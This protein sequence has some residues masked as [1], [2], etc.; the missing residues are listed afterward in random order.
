MLS[1][2]D[3][4]V[5]LG[6]SG[7]FGA[8][9]AALLDGTSVPTLFIASRTKAIRV[10]DLSYD[11]VTWDLSAMEDFHPSVVI[12]CAFLTRDLV[13]TMPFDEYI[14]TNRL[15][16]RRMLDTVRI[17]S[18]RRA[19]T[20]SSGAAV[21]PQDALLGT[22]VENPYGLLKREAE[23]ALE[24]LA[25]ETGVSGVIARAWSVSGAYVQKPTSYAFS[26]FIL[27]A[28][29]GHIDI[30]AAS[31]V[32]RRYAGVDDL[33][34]VALATA[35]E[36]GTRVVDSG[37][38]LVEIQQLAEQVIATVNPSAT[39]SRPALSDAPPD[40]YYSSGKS[41]ISSLESLE[42]SAYSLED[43][44]RAARLGLGRTLV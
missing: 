8:T 5:V 30:S 42:F 22:L 2:S 23:R 25:N 38:E 10:Q 44:I 18:V 15:L 24:A 29:A 31:K 19:V 7:W 43:Q 14:D 21:Y 13:G 1:G 27:Q 33:L 40:L 20:V 17:P 3:R 16:T 39:I 32:Y 6:A 11:C 37:G 9:T 26:D 41:W 12:D 34:A 36:S 4:V 28:L 35:T